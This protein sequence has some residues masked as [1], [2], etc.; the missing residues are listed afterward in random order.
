MSPRRPHSLYH[1][2][3]RDRGHINDIVNRG[4]DV[5]IRRFDTGATRDSV[6]GKLRY[7]GYFSPLVLK[8]RAQYMRIGGTSPV[9]AMISR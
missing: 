9:A 1:G 2:H 7:E 4:H 8:A 6:A 5:N 3:V